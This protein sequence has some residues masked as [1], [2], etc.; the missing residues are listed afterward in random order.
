MIKQIEKN[1][2]FSLFNIDNF[3]HLEQILDEYSPSLAQYHLENFFSNIDEESFLNKREI[4]NSF[5]IG[6]YSI[7]L[8]YDDNI[9]LESIKDNLI[10][11]YQTSS[12]F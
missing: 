8:D 7:Y 4:Q 3:I 6:D 12:L 2:I 5:N 10:D 1:G 11:S 9:Y